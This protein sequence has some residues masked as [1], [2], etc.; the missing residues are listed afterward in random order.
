MIYPSEYDCIDC[1]VHVVQI[2]PPPVPGSRCAG[3]Q[4]IA[5]IPDPAHRA[6]LRAQLIEHAVIGAPRP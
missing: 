3:C 1:G 4:W 2:A 5:A 6:A